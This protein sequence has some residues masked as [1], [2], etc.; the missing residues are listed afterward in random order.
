ML[1][2]ALSGIFLLDMEQTNLS[3]SWSLWIPALLL[4]TV[5]MLWFGYSAAR[6]LKSKGYA[7]GIDA[8]IGERAEV[9][10]VNVNGNAKVRVNGELWECVWT[11]ATV[12]KEFK[13][14]QTVLVKRQEGFKLF[15]E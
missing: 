2:L 3:I 8:L 10:K 4:G 5:F 9:V 11:S 12:G 1:C 13:K 15:V 6:A 7:Q 14:G